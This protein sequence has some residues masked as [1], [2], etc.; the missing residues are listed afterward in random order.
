MNIEDMQLI[1]AEQTPELPVII[2]G[3]FQTYSSA[4]LLVAFLNLFLL[5]CFGNI[6]LHFIKKCWVWL[7]NFSCILWLYRQRFNIGIWKRV[8]VQK[9]TQSHSLADQNDNSLSKDLSAEKNSK[10]K[11]ALKFLKLMQL[12]TITIS[13]FRSWFLHLIEFIQ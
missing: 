8:K 12:L 9:C 5:Y 2:T 11:K 4:H 13:F 6:F 10:Q 7:G 1:Y 3:S